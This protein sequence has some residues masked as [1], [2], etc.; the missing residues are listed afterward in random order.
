MSHL[1]LRKSKHHHWKADAPTM[2]DCLVRIL[3]RWHRWAI[4]LCKWARS[5]RNGNSEHYHA[6][7]KEFLFPKIEEVDMDNIWIQQDGATCHT[8]NV[9]MD[10]LRTVFENRIM[11]RNSDV[12]SPPWNCDLTPLDYFLWGSRL[13]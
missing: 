5:H 9:T 2:S 11:S 8:A 12:N 3:V 10:I 13:G 1:G 6:M 4:F 7:L